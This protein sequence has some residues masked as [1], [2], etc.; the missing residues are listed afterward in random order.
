MRHGRGAARQGRYAGLA[1]A[2]QHKRD[3][4]DASF[5]GADR[6]FLRPPILFGWAPVAAFISAISVWIS[7]PKPALLQVCLALIEA[8][9][10]PL[11]CL[12]R[13]DSGKDDAYAH[14]RDR[15]ERARSSGL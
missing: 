7:V 13:H 3:P 2:Q 12:G 10:T 11:S 1:Y 15:D 5:A 8:C 9:E 4:R 14:S 6:K